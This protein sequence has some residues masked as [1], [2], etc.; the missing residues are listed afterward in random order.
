[1]KPFAGRI[2]KLEAIIKAG[3]RKEIIGG[4]VL[5]GETAQTALDRMVSSGRIREDQ[6]EQVQLVRWM[7]PDEAVAHER[8]NLGLSAP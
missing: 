6:R 1:M 5:D 2:E 7:R 4:F 8:R 3:R